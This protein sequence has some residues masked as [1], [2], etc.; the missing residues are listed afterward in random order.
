MSEN[1]NHLHRRNIVACVW[2]FDKT[3]IPGYMQRPLFE[4]FGID[5]EKF[6]QE[7]NTLPEIYAKRGMFVSPDTVYLNHLLSYIKTGPLKGL[8]NADLRAL[9]EKLLFYEGLPGFFSRL[10][11]F[12]AE[13]PLYAK[14]DIRLEHYIISTGLAEMIRGS[15]IAGEVDGVF[16]CEFIEN[17]LPPFYLEQGELA[18]P[19][20]FEISQIG[21]MVDNT[22]KTRYVFE[23]NKGTNRNAAIDV[24]AKML[25][26]DR[27]VPIANMVYVADGPS[28][29]PVFSVVRKGGGKCLAVY[30]PEREDEFQQNDQLLE[31]GRV[32]AYGPADYRENTQTARWLK[33]QVRKICGRIADESERALAQRVKR[34]PRHLHREPEPSGEPEA[35]EGQG[36]LF[37]EEL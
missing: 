8:R 28:D 32:H 7:V 5:E 27:R 19:M 12:V 26:E 31:D 6:W 33:L 29:V 10:K 18:I 22:I 2:D 15:A 30:D 17:P 25:P 1:A 23:I 21:V 36:A 11:T 9:G 4:Q 37:E 16:G 3:L 20:D 24:N 14:H 35:I 13:D 34:P